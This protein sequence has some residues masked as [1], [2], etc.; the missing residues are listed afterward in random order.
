MLFAT[1]NQRG[2]DWFPIAGAGASATIRLARD[3]KLGVSGGRREH[4]S[5][6]EASA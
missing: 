2:R 3:G 1:L 5:L 4:S 6:L